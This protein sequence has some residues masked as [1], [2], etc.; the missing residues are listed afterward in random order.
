MTLAIYFV[1]FA[2]FCRGLQ[3]VHGTG[4]T[5]ASL[6]CGGSFQSINILDV[7]PKTANRSEVLFTLER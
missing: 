2:G 7:L 5:G 3:E 1:W 6:H 4:S